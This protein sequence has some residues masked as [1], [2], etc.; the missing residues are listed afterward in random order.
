MRKFMVV[1]NTG[2]VT[3]KQAREGG[4]RSNEVIQELGPDIQWLE[5][6]V[7]PNKV[8]CL[9]VAKNEEIVRKHSEMG[10]FTLSEI[11]EVTAVI[12]PTS[13]EESH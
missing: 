3:P 9:Y 11:H 5:S 10:P 6:F 7:T 4:R 8:Y 12:D 2:P 13:P 1:R